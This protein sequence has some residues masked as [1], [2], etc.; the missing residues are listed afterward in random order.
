LILLLVALPALALEPPVMKVILTITGKVGDKNT[1]R[2]EIFD[3]AMLE[4]LPQQ[5]FNTKPPWDALPIQLT[6]PLLRDALLP[7]RPAN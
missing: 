5:T 6:G 3:L 7:K 4:K 2:A 1:A